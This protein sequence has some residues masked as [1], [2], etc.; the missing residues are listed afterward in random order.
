VN[1]A[2]GLGGLG[3][4]P[5]GEDDESG[6]PDRRSQDSRRMSPMGHEAEMWDRAGGRGKRGK[7]A[8]A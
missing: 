2:L 4:S 1:D 3:L 7:R 8:I 5:S 6:Q